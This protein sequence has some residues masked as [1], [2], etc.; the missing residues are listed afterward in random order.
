M[1]GLELK[2]YQGNH[3]KLLHDFVMQFGLPWLITRFVPF[4][5]HFT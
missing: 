1:A 3:W 4:M 5:M 2:E